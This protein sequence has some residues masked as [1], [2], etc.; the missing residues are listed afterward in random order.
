MALPL[1]RETLLASARLSSGFRHQSVLKV[2]TDLGEAAVAKVWT[3]C[4]QS[5][6]QV[7]EHLESSSYLRLSLREYLKSPSGAFEQG[8][9]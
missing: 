4:F 1:F 8:R 6:Q 5:V 7:I 2:P 9:F 3:C